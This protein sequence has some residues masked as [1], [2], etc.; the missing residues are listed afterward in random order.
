MDEPISDEE[1]EYVRVATVLE[2]EYRSESQV[3]K[4]RI[5]DLSEGGAFVDVANPER[6]GDEIE[7]TLELPGSGEPI[8]GKAVV[9][10]QQPTIGMGI[11]FIGLTDEQRE[12]IKFYVAAEFFKSF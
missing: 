9:V 8:A 1:R 2:F 6:E 5:E 3:S 7:F 12:Q 4:A 10:W 11:K